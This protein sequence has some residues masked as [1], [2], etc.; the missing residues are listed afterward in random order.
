MWV[1]WAFVDIVD[2]VDMDGLNG[3]TVRTVRTVLAVLAALV[4][5]DDGEGDDAHAW[6]YGRRLGGGFEG[7]ALPLAG[8]GRRDPVQSRPWAGHRSPRCTRRYGYTFVHR[9]P[10][11]VQQHNARSVWWL[12]GARVDHTRWQYAR[13]GAWRWSGRAMER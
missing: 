12:D 4:V 13:W 8:A 10:D 6:A 3:W 9:D 7:S 2:I 1:L 5:W 11:G